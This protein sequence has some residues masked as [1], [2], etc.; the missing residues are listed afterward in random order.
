MM[1]TTLLAAVLGAAFPFAALAQ[2]ADDLKNDEMKAADVLSYGMGQAQHRYS[3]LTQINTD[4]SACKK[5]QCFVVNQGHSG[6]AFFETRDYV[7][8]K[9]IGFQSFKHWNPTL[10]PLL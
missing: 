5:C 8:D 1:R 10:L 6:V 7:W 9:S 2:T 4:M 3:P